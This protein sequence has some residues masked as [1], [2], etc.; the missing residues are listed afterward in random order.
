MTLPPLPARWYCVSRDGLATLCASKQNAIE[1]ASDCAR[2]YPR[3]APYRAVLMCDV[4]AERERWQAAA[5]RN[6]HLAVAMADIERLREQHAQAM[7]DMDA[8]I[9]RLRAALQRQV[10][11]IEVWLATGLPAGP[12]ESREIYEQMRAA[13]KD[14]T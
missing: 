8:E 3:Q 2:D 12:D 13:L 11:N 4:A 5:N 6:G 9:D 14:P 7:A 10:R 1:M